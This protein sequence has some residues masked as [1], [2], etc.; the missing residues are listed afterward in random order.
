MN[1]ISNPPD[2]SSLPESIRLL[3]LV[4]KLNA[5]LARTSVDMESR[6]GVTAPQ[7]FILRFVGLAPGITTVGLAETI[8]IETERVH[9][10]LQQLVSANLLVESGGSPGFYL[11]AKGAGINAAMVGTVEDAVS[12]ASDDSSAYERTSFRRMLERLVLHLG[13]AHPRKV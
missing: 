12:K 2:S 5:A 9:A 1:S 6:L 7:R 13:D 3:Q 8:A 11:T 10:D 4:W